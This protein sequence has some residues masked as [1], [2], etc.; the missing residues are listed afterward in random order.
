MLFLHFVEME[1]QMKIS[2]EIVK[3]HLEKCFKIGD[4]RICNEDLHLEKALFYSGDD[5]PEYATLYICGD[6]RLPDKLS[7]KKQLSLI[8]V[9][10]TLP[11]S[12]RDRTDWILL[13]DTTDLYS[14]WNQLVELFDRFHQWEREMLMLTGK[15]M[16]MADLERFLEI[17]SFA[18]ENGLSILDANFKIAAEDQINIKYGNYP[19]EFVRENKRDI[20]GSLV[21][22]MKFNEQYQ[23]IQYKKECFYYE[24]DILPHRCLCKNIFVGEQFVYRL[25]ITECVRPFCHTDELLLEYCAEFLEHGIAQT[26]VVLVQNHERL[27]TQLGEIIRSGTVN[28]LALRREAEKIVWDL[29]DCYQVLYVQPSAQD[30]YFSSLDYQCRELMRLFRDAAAFV[31]DTAIICVIHKE[32]G[33]EENNRDADFTVYVREN[34]FLAG[35]SNMFNGLYKIHD[36][37]RQAQLAL[38]IG[39]KEKP[40]HWIHAFSDVTFGYLLNKMTEDYSAQELVSP[41]F[42][43][44]K[45]YDDENGTEYIRTLETYL[46][47]NMNVV[48]TANQLFV[49]RATV[50]YRIK[51]ICEIGH[52]DLKDKRELLHLGITFTLL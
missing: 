24:E 39:M 46:E 12:V 36:Y 17:S 26:D 14:V 15:Q 52:T 29:E 37:Y 5:N 31:Y 48:Q 38:S 44:L 50:I 16:T 8:V 3:K 47:N 23:K 20:P 51:R 2:L 32:A 1:N 19:A 35:T 34:D 27:I 21:S 45:Q 13:D 49:H 41:I 42:L 11:R 4:C 30:V 9:G 22:E 33:N 7:E 10:E 6:G 25:I 43:R 18:F 40:T 28:R